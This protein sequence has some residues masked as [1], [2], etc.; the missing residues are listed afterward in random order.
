MARWAARSTSCPFNLQQ[1]QGYS[2]AAAGAAFLPF[3]IIVF[4]LSR[5]TGGMVRWTGAKLPLV[6][7]PLL[8]AVGFLLY[9]RPGIGGSYWTTFFPAIVVMALGMA[10]VIAPLTTA[11][12]GAV[13]QERA[14]VASGVNNAVSRAAGLLAIAVLG[15]AVAAA[16][17]NAFDSHLAA[18]HLAPATRQALD[19]QRARLAGAQI[20]AGLPSATHAAIQ[21]AIGNSYVAGFRVAMGVS[22]AL[23]ALSAVIAGVLIPGRP[24][25]AGASVAAPADDAATGAGRRI[26]TGH[27]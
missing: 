6:I 7:G 15:L 21:Q 16:F 5:W 13:A 2:P 23:S 25:R 14:G 3:T 18:L 27:A 17:N 8:V 11:V 4:A 10:L 22:A 24:A 20:P 19:A 1:V 26:I 9:M 12:M